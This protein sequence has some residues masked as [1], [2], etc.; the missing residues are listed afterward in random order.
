MKA[1]FTILSVMLFALISNTT[2]DV[3]D[4]DKTK[5]VMVES[6]DDV[7]HL[8]TSK[9]LKVEVSKSLN[10]AT[11]KTIKK[12]ALDQLKA[13]AIAKGYTHLFIEHSKAGMAISKRNYRVTLKA[14]AY[15]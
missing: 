13:K 15:K 4:Q 8:S 14:I 11:A 1:L 2:L 6:V 12:M 5:I 7:Q 3:T 10:L 9:K